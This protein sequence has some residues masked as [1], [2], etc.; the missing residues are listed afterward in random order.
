MSNDIDK[1]YKHKDNDLIKG[2]LA[3]M[4]KQMVKP[5]TDITVKSLAVTR[6]RIDELHDVKR[7]TDLVE[8][9]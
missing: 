2:C 6:K 4:T 7:L 5:T 3:I 1:Q 8:F 9:S